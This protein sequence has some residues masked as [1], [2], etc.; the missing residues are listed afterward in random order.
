MGARP[1]FFDNLVTADVPESGA[2]TETLINTLSGVQ[3][4]FPGQAVKLSCWAAILT[5]AA[6]TGMTLRV[7]RDSLT[8]AIVNEV[9]TNQGDIQL[10][11]ISTLPLECVDPR[12]EVANGVYVLTF[13][14]AGE[15]A[16]STAAASF[17]SA[18]VD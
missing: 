8:G 3:S 2:N 14:G 10:A 5:G 7:R 12:P 4:E 15:G 1:H 6:T 13:Q 18:R 16:V 9:N 11:R 17:M